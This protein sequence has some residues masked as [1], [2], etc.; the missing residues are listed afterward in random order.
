MAGGLRNSL[1]LVGIGAIVIIVGAV[2]ISRDPASG[3]GAVSGNKNMS[4]T[5][6]LN[7]SAFE[8]GQAI[9]S[10]YTC[11]GD[12]VSPLLAIAGVPE[13]AKSLALIMDDP[14]VP[15]QL[16]PDGVFDHW[17]LFNIAPETREIPEN[18]SAGTVGANGSGQSA[19]TGPCPPAQYE[20]SEHRYFFRLYALD[21]EL[22][23]PAGAS[24]KD[25]LAAMEGHII[26][27][28]ELMGRYKRK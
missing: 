4:S 10:E 3:A 19:Y 11:D 9:P 6:T 13:G 26:D 2:M 23:I 21:A 18:G 16:K 12:N 14:D 5:L 22:D 28:A 27:R 15:T 20:P 8:N 25:V 1:L 17:T 24:K 7:T